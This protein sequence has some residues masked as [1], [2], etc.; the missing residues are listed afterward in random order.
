MADVNSFFSI[1]NTINSLSK[2]D[3]RQ[4]ADYVQVIEAFARTSNQ[5][6]YVIDYEKKGFEYV[7]SNPLF[8]NGHTLEQVLEMGYDFYFKCVPEDDLNLLLKINEVGFQFYDQI[9]LEERKKYSIAYD[10]NLKTE[11][12]KT[13][14][15]NQELTPM[16]LNQEGKIWKALCMVSLSS[17]QNA[18]NVII[19]KNGSNETYKYDFEESYWESL[20]RIEL[21]EREQEILRCSIQGYAINEIADK[22]F[23]SSDTVKFHR[24]KIYEKL[25]VGNISEAILKANNLL[26]L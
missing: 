8:L 16:F 17:N 18:G 24:R 14:L 7:S 26:L 21:S 1:N 23:I 19:R 11:A 12:N 10:F 4:T 22:L 13:I 6:I 5:S 3:L 25:E 15:I 2:G 9:P 20:D